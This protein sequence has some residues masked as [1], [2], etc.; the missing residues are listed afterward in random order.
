MSRRLK[1]AATGALLAGS[2]AA[3]TLAG[4]LGVSLASGAS[5]GAMPVG[6]A[7]VAG[8]G[9]A[10]IGLRNTGLGKVLV[11]GR[12]FT[13]YAFTRDSK[14]KDRCIMT[15]GCTHIWPVVTTQGRPVAGSG[16][17]R[18]LLGSIN[19]GSGRRQVTYAGHPLYTYAFDGSPGETDYVGAVEFGGRWRA[20]RASGQETG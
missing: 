2:V 14:N 4:V 19:L 9:P 12:G 16:V 1:I 13:L 3:F 18:S 6:L 11:N 7:H 17:K 8:A 15:S 10:K 20:V 5:S